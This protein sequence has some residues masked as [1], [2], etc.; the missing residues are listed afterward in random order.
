MDFKENECKHL[1]TTIVVIDAFDIH[2]QIGFKCV[3]CKKIIK[4]TTN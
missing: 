2:E 1:E 4:T 3:E